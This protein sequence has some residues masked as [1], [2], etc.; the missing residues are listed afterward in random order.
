MRTGPRPD[1]GAGPGDSQCYRTP[2]T[3]GDFHTRGFFGS[4]MGQGDWEQWGRS[5]AG[6][7]WGWGRAGARVAAGRSLPACLQLDREHKV[8]GLLPPNLQG[9]VHIRRVLSKVYDDV[10]VPLPSGPQGPLQALSWLLGAPAQA[11]VG[12]WDPPACSADSPL[13]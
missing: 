11:V 5:G 10:S 1:P 3:K 2:K 12:G 6:A 13:L 9:Q 7:G 8:A 4:H